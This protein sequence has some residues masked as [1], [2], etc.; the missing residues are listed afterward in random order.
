MSGDRIRSELA[1]VEAEL[2]E[3]EAEY[4]TL[5]ARINGLKAQQA[6]LRESLAA[7]NGHGASNEE[8]TRMKK[9]DAIV[10]VV[11][12]PMTI[13]D[14]LQALHAAG[15]VHEAYMPVSMY[16]GD[17]VQYRLLKRIRHGLY[18]PA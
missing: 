11:D 10:A 7:G 15:R 13:N 3:A 9:A 18:G 5:G 14:V 12:R 6:A 1:R 8:T 2:A 17:L 4:A 16:L